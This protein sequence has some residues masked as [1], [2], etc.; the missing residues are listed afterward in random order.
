MR[1]ALILALACFATEARGEEFQTVTLYP[2]GSSCAPSQVTE[3][4][5]L[6]EP[7][8]TPLGYA[9]AGY[10][11]APTQHETLPWTKLTGDRLVP[12]RAQTSEAAPK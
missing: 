12:L 6:K 4:G 7:V 9:P 1:F 10:R 3:D 8:C 5:H 11:I 2:T